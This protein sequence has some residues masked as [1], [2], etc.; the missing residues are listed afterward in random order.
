MSEESKH[1]RPG[2]R[3]PQLIPPDAESVGE[4]KPSRIMPMAIIGAG[5]LLAVL[6][7]L[8]IFLP[9]GSDT[10]SVKA[11]APP[12]EAP[13]ATAKPAQQEAPVAD[14]GAQE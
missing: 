3:P 8:V 9:M 13:A 7:L 5:L 11:P 12:P 10:R 4:A 14:S 2:D 6:A 1:K